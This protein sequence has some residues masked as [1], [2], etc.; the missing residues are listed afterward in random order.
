MS[1][2]MQVCKQ[3]VVPCCVTSDHITCNYILIFIR[4]YTLCILHGVMTTIIKLLNPVYRR[5]VVLVIF[6]FDDHLI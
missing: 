3:K 4:K 5:T 2:H 6:T 1:L